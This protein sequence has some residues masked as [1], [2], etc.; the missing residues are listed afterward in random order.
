MEIL[1]REQGLRA[2]AWAAA[3]ICPATFKNS[4]HARANANVPDRRCLMVESDTLTED[5]VGAVFNWHRDHPPVAARLL[6]PTGAGLLGGGA[7]GKWIKIHETSA[8]ITIRTNGHGEARVDG[9][10]RHRM[11]NVETGTLKGHPP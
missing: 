4:T 11:L 2:R 8:K 10:M 3:I 7:V 6:Q 1:L 5:Q 9:A